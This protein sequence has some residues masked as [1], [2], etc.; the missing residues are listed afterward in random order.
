MA[1]LESSVP[2]Q[3]TAA[4]TQSRAIGEAAHAGTVSSVILIPEGNVTANA[5]NYRTFRVLNKG[6]T[7]R[8]VY[9]FTAAWTLSWRLDAEGDGTR[10]FLEHRGFDLDDK[11]MAQAFERMGPGWCDVVLPRLARVAAHA[12]S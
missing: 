7:C 11:R 5:T 1:T 6:Q 3:G 10:V 8:F 12:R 4:T 9:T 2:A